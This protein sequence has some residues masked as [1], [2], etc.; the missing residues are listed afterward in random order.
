M[1]YTH[2]GISSMNGITDSQETVSPQTFQSIRD[3]AQR[4]HLARL[5]FWSVN[6]DRPCP[7]GGVSE[8]CSGIAQSDW[9]FTQISAG[10]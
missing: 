5:A 8:S 7:G 10:F 1:A 9:Q 3:Y 4:N 6:R 2:I